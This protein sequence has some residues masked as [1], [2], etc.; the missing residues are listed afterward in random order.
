MNQHGYQRN[1]RQ[2]RDNSRMR[3]Q[4]TQRVETPDVINNATGGLEQKKTK[5][6]DQVTDIKVQAPTN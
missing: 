4:Q 2:G 3:N 1:H 5:L 6:T